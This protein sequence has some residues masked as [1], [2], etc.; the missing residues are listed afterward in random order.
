MKFQVMFRVGVSAKSPEGTRWTEIAVS[1]GNEVIQ[2]NVGPTGLTW[3]T[4]ACG[5]AIVRVGVTRDNLQGT[6][7]VEVRNPGSNALKIIQLSV[8]TNAVWAVTQ[9]KQVWFRKGV[10]GNVFAC[11]KIK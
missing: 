5:R 8:G 3:A 11:C 1:L 6:N 7:W 2:L 9:D 10:K 4:L